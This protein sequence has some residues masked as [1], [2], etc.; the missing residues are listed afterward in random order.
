MTPSPARADA[1]K[2]PR[3]R[4]I[5]GIWG[6]GGEAS[7]YPQLPK[8]R[9][10]PDARRSDTEDSSGHDLRATMV[11]MTLHELIRADCRC[12]GSRSAVWPA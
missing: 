8:H 6:Y 3:V 2:T 7:S 12:R 10:E 5:R 1:L 9:E 11:G 4:A